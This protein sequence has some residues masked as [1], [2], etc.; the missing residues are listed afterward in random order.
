MG[1][2]V[3]AV[4][5]G[6]QRSRKLLEDRRGLSAR[7]LGQCQIVNRGTRNFSRMIFS[8]TSR[9]VHGIPFAAAGSCGHASLED[10]R[11]L[12]LC[13][14]YTGDQKLGKSSRVSDRLFLCA[15]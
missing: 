7:G 5:K 13:I 8:A 10:L 2:V 3:G 14:D 12:C 9:A 1:S 11:G 6:V 15:E 4:R